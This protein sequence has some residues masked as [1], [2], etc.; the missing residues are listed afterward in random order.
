MQDGLMVGRTV[1]ARWTDDRFVFTSRGWEELAWVAVDRKEASLLEAELEA[2]LEALRRW[3]ENGGQ[4]IGEPGRAAPF[5]GVAKPARRT[6]K[7]RQR[8]ASVP[9]DPFARL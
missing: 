3:R 1:M 6:L 8:P 5:S 9:S 2:V 7:V 4:G